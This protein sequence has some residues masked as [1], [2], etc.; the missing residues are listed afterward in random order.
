[1]SIRGAQKPPFQVT[2]AIGP[3]ATGRSRPGRECNRDVE[4]LIRVVRALLTIPRPYMSSAE[5][6]ERALAD[7]SPSGNRNI[8]VGEDFLDCGE[9]DAD[10]A[11]LDDQHGDGKRDLVVARDDLW[12]SAVSAEARPGGCVPA[13]SWLT[14]SCSLPG[15]RSA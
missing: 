12:R 14:W 3:S 15:G 5:D 11:G 1:M 8:G 9:H 13:G 4:P 7:A 2:S 6:D 10:G